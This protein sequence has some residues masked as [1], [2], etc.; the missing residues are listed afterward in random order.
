MPNPCRQRSFWARIKLSKQNYSNYPIS[1]DNQFRSSRF[2]LVANLFDSLF[3]YY[4]FLILCRTSKSFFGFIALFNFQRSLAL[5]NHH[6]FFK[7]NGNVISHA[8]SICQIDFSIFFKFF[9]HSLDSA[10]RHKRC[11]RKKY[12][13]LSVF[14]KSNSDFFS[15]FLRA[16]RAQLHSLPSATGH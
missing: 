10:L 7:R 2:N 13:I 4:D 14:V 16:P 1:S 6:R 15:F 5:Y 9:Q 3:F 12:S 11:M 8:F